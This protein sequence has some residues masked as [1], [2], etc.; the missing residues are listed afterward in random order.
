MYTHTQQTSSLSFCD[1]FRRRGALLLVRLVLFGGGLIRNPIPSK[2]SEGERKRARSLSLFSLSLS[3]AALSLSLSQKK[4]YRGLH[5]TKTTNGFL[6]SML[7]R[8]RE[9]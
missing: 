5:T 6:L 8:R 2:K 7:F 9:I 4:L 1:R 3:P